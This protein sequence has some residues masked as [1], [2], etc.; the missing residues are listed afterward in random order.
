MDIASIARE[1][2]F[3]EAYALPAERFSHYERR[4]ANDA[5]HKGGRSL[6]IDVREAAPWANAIVALIRTYRPFLPGVPLSGN[7][8]GSNAA[9][10]AA[11]AMLI[12]LKREGV[13]AELAYV[14]VRELLLRSGIGVPLKNGLTAIEPY[15]TRYSVETLAVCLPDAPAALAAGTRVLL[16]ETC[17][18]CENACPSAGIGA[19]GYD[20]SRCA[21]AYM[22]GDTMEDWVMDAMTTMLGCELCQNVCPY[23]RAVS[24]EGGLPDALALERLLGGDVKPALALVGGN[25]NKNGRL[26]QHACVLAARLGR[27][28]LLPLIKPLLDDRR[29]AVRA[30]ARYAFGRLGQSSGAD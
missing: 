15:G 28:D 19:D 30:A 1:Y 17:H 29:E 25:L 13:R 18:A 21:R 2:G 16:C 8:I 27:T 7:Y 3:A 20:F 22:G 4:L 9:Y 14:P 5:L 23:N 12:R 24:P 26:I 11:K 6:T 10:H